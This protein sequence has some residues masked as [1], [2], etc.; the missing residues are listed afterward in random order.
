MCCRVKMVINKKSWWHHYPN[1]FH[2]NNAV[3]CPS[4]ISLFQG[5][6]EI[7]KAGFRVS[8]FFL[9]TDQTDYLNHVIIRYKALDG[10]LYFTVSIH[11]NYVK[12][13]CL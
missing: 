6:A 8:L 1:Y 12:R 11:W 9:V 5:N 10:N 4:R 2:N 3:L 13:S 7:L